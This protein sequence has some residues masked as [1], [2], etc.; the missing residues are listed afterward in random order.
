MRDTFLGCTIHIHHKGDASKQ[1]Q[2]LANKQLE[3]QNTLTKEQLGM[4]RDTLAT[5][6]GGVSQFLTPEGQGFDPKTLAAM[7]SLAM[8]QIPENFD[9]IRKQLM[10]NLAQR[11]AVGGNQPVAGSFLGNLGSLD[12]QEAQ[13]RSSA[14]QDIQVKNAVANL[15]NRFS[16]TNAMLGVGSQYNPA[17]FIGG[18][19]SALG[20]G[21]EAAHNVDQASGGL[22]GSL[23]GAAAGVGSSA[24]TAWCPASGTKILMADGTEKPIELL[25][26]GE[27]IMGIDGEPC[28]IE[29][30]PSE[31]TEII[32]V[33]FD[34]GHVTRN[35]PT[36]AFALPKGGFT[37]SAKSKGKQV[38]TDKGASTVVSVERDGVERVFNIITDGS[39][40]YCADGV[41]ALGVGD[42]ERRIPMDTWGRIGKQLST[43]IAN[44]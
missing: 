5:V 7:Q 17:P 44:G 25:A 22:W 16:A 21:V 2:A 39:H 40:T 30:I 32:R 29:E 20:S 13:Q 9:A 42:A 27:K 11:G 36:H 4:Q 35:S 33:T 8:N 28:T 43:E 26:V 24:I 19:S 12:A 41:W 37:V 15:Q 31:Y 38:L 6:K 18:A 3:M 34:D 1:Q 14:L 23:L 10:V